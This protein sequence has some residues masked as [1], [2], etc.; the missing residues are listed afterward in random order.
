MQRTSKMNMFYQLYLKDLYDIRTELFLSLI[1]VFAADLAIFFRVRDPGLAQTLAVLAVLIP[2]TVSFVSA[3]R[4]L[5]KEWTNKT[6]YLMMSLPVRGIMVL[7]AKFSALMTQYLISTLAAIALGAS[8]IFARIPNF[9]ETLP[10][11][12]EIY[13]VCLCIYALVLWFMAYLVS[14]IFLS[15][16]T[17][18][19]FRK[20]Q[21]LISLG[22]CLL[23][24]WGSSKMIEAL[25]GNVEIVD[26]GL[27]F[28]ELLMSG[29]TSGVVFWCLLQ[30][31][32]TALWL[33]TAGF[34]FD[35]KLE[36]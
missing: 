9:M 18:R 26:L 5:I 4:I 11:K 35:K 27:S 1:L 3:I 28:T 32:F 23:L 10:P 16:M 6:I 30:A 29:K 13:K 15:Q 34:I 25:T 36:I 8:V 31:A 20:F 7:G 21:G 2:V 24:E 33:N 12:L 14:L 17:S 19:L 22:V